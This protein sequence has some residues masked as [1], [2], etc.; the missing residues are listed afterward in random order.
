[1]YC[2]RERYFFSAMNAKPFRFA[3]LSHPGRLRK[4]NEDSCAGSLDS[5][6]FVVCD[7][8]GG[9]AAGEVASHLATETFLAHLAP[10]KNGT[11]APRTATP[12]VR[13]DAAIHASNQAVFQHSRRFPELDGMGTTLVA[14]LLEVVASPNLN[15]CCTVSLAHVGDSRCYRFRSGALTLLTEDHSLVEE[16]LRAGQITA[17]EAE[18]HPMRNIITR[19]IGSSAHVEPEIRHL[20]ELPGDLLLLTSDGLT[21]ELSDRALEAIFQRATSRGKPL[22]LEGLCQTLVDEANDAGGTDNITVLLVAF[23]QP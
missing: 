15:S 10:S 8:M 12:D 22:N 16:Q 3:M 11:A 13:L 7:G 21:R 6:A 19:A 4:G 5:G 14:L 20:D 9:A 18:H 17:F 1:V 23:D 2:F